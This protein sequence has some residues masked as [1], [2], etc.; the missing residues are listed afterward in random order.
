MT[1]E[2]AMAILDYFF[3][4]W[5]HFLQLCVLTFLTWGHIKIGRDEHKE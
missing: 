4:N 5:V 3:G 2:T 1:M